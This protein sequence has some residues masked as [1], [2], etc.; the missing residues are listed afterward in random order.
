MPRVVDVRPGG[1]Q[2]GELREVAG[3][4]DEGGHAPRCGRPH[5]GIE[6]G[7]VIDHVRSAQS[8]PAGN[9]RDEAPCHPGAAHGSIMTN[10]RHLPLRV[11]ATTSRPDP[12]WS[13]SRR[14]WCRAWCL[15]RV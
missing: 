10:S 9:E 8:R 7:G 14:V 1:Q 4:M 2:P 11:A 5:L 3:E 13:R 6:V 12:E 15:G